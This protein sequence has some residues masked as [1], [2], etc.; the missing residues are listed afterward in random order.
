[1]MRLR[2]GAQLGT[3]LIFIGY[4]GINAFNLEIAPGYRAKEH[5]EEQNN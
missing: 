5:Q 3:L 4:A 2:V 1:M